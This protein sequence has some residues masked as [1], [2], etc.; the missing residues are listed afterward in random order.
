MGV[1]FLVFTST[2]SAI[3]ATTRSRNTTPTAAR[4]PATTGTEINILPAPVDEPVGTRTGP[5]GELSYM[6]VPYWNGTTE[7]ESSFL[8]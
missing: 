2:S 3:M 6:Y 8:S 4:K 1:S 7:E 5:Q